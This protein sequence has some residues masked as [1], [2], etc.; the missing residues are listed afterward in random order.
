MLAAIEEFVEIVRVEVPEV[1]AFSGTVRGLNK[2]VMPLGVPPVTVAASDTVPAN[3][4]LL[5]E[6]VD[7]ADLPAAR[8]MLAGLT[9]IV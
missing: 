2:V 5:R 3:P 6:I 1:P 9:V 8:P 7:V 4:V